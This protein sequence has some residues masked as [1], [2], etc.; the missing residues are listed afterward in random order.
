MERTASRP[1][2]TRMLALVALGGLI[3]MTALADFIGILPPERHIEIRIR[4]L[5]KRQPGLS[6]DQARALVVPGERILPGLIRA[7]APVRPLRD[8]KL[9]TG[10]QGRIIRIIPPRTGGNYHDP[11]AHETYLFVAYGKGGKPISRKPVLISR[12]HIRGPLHHEF[13]TLL[14]IRRLISNRHELLGLGVEDRVYR[15]SLYRHFD[16]DGKLGLYTSGGRAIRGR[17]IPNSLDSLIENGYPLLPRLPYKMPAALLNMTRSNW[18]RMPW[19]SFMQSIVYGIARSKR[20]PSAFNPRFRRQALATAGLLCTLARVQPDLAPAAIRYRAK[21]LYK[22][23]AD[24]IVALAYLMLPLP[25]DRRGRPNRYI[26]A[27]YMNPALPLDYADIAEATADV[28]ASEPGLRLFI[29]KI[30]DAGVSGPSARLVRSLLQLAVNSHRDRQARPIP[31]LQRAATRALDNIFRP[32]PNVDE[33]DRD[34]YRRVLYRFLDSEIPRERRYACQRLSKYGW[35][36]PQYLGNTVDYLFR[37]ARVRL[38]ARKGHA[39]LDLA[40]I[41]LAGAD[42]VRCLHTMLQTLDKRHADVKRTISEHIDRIR[43]RAV[44]EHPDRIDRLFIRIWDQQ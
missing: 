23:G 14:D 13:D 5:L 43:R 26:G 10:F 33:E 44:G 36:D 8:S 38:G 1:V 22:L 41:R 32:D 17:V 18:Q 20:Y 29:G 21:H 12:Y 3:P 2:R 40:G 4:A 9:G 15:Q 28:I 27:N 11:A 25:P 39:R 24:S 42:H 19:H 16:P 7:L 37:M 35:G 30:S 34:S 31:R 6:P